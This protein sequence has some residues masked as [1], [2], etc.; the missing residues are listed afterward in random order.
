MSNAEATRP[1]LPPHQSYAD[2]TDQLASIPL[3]FPAR[4]TWLIV[5]FDP[6][7]A[8]V[9]TRSMEKDVEK[10]RVEPFCTASVAPVGADLAPSRAKAS[11]PTPRTASSSSGIRFRGGTRQS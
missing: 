1:I 5:P 11:V 2:V 3:H 6:P 8:M 7:V 9:L 4:R 10:V